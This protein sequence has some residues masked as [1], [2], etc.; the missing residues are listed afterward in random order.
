MLNNGLD[1]CSC[2]STDCK[3]NGNCKECLEFHKG[4]LTRCQRDLQKEEQKTVKS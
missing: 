2:P 4:S 1:K 3:R